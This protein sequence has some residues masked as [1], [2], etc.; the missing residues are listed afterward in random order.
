MLTCVSY[1][2]IKKIRNNNKGEKEI[3]IKGGKDTCK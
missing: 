3:I 1:A 2:S